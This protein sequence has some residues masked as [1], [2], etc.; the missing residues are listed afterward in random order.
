[1]TADTGEDVEKED[2]S[3]IAGGIASLYNHSGNQS[4][5]S[6]GNWDYFYLKTQAYHSFLCTQKM[7]QHVTR[8]HDPL[9]SSQPYLSEPEARDNPDVPQQKNGSRKCGTFI[10]WSTIQL[11]KSNEFMKLAG[12][13]MELENSILSEVSQ[14]QKNTN[15]MYSLISAY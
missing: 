3:S 4:G 2:H 13:W 9:C 6:S 10:Q 7:L 11:L 12:K 15:G 8:T 14:T 5:D 1:V